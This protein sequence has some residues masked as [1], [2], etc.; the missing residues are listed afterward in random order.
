MNAEE[1]AIVDTVA[2]FVGHAPLMI[3]AEGAP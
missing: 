1:Q 2:A 3:I